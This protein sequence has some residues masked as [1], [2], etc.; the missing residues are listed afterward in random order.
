MTTAS[1][2]RPSPDSGEGAAPTINN[3]DQSASNIDMPTGQGNDENQHQVGALN[4]GW[5][6]LDLVKWFGYLGIS[7]LAY[8]F[9][10]H[11]S[12]VVVAR[13]QTSRMTDGTS[14]HFMKEV[15]RDA[16]IRG[17]FRGFVAMSIGGVLGEYAYMTLLEYGRAHTPLETQFQRDC[18]SGAVADVAS[19]LIY[20]PFGLIS[21]RQMTAGYGVCDYPYQ[22]SYLSA[23]AIAQ[24]KGWRGFF[25]GLTPQMLLMPA[26]GLWWGIYGRTKTELYARHDVLL[27]MYGP[28]ATSMPNWATSKDDNYVLNFGAGATAG[29]MLTYLANPLWVIKARMQVMDVPRRGALRYV[30][31][32]LITKEGYR[33][34]YKGATLNCVIYALEGSVFG[35]LYEKWKELASH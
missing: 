9:V 6:D 31:N 16:G 19:A 22:N 27:S 15:Y 3:N 28:Y 13:Q 33:A 4:R 25:V 1:L 35:M 23:R 17:F 32:D 2:H 21:N 7:G 18:V 30:W 24:A 10:F 8:S 14:W 12:Y 11:P 26:S 29:A 20:I 5:S 34:L